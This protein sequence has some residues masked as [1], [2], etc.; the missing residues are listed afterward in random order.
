MAGDAL[1]GVAVL[2][3]REALGA[4]GD[5]LVELDVAPDDAGLADDH[6]R[7]VVDGEMAAYLR[8]GVYVD[9]RL[10]MGHFGDDAGNEGHAQHQ[11][12][13][14]DAVVA[15]GADAR[16]A[17]D[18]LAKRM[19]SGVAVVGGLHVGGQQ[20][21][22]AGQDADEVGSFPCGILAQGIGAAGS[23]AVVV[24]QAEGGQYLSAQL[25]EQ[26]FDVDADVVGQ[27][28]A[29][30]RGI[31]E[32]ARKDNGTRQF[33]NAPQVAARRQGIPLRMAQ[34][35]A[36]VTFGGGQPVDGLRQDVGEVQWTHQNVVA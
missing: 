26:L 17:A 31:S 14:G 3:Q 33:D 18:D 6:A 16:I 20:G 24:R 29:V 12:F 23:V 4:E 15:D 19:G 2:V 22:Q 8:A 36:L 21:A 5:A 13:V 32:V 30:H 1:D 11:Q 10:A 25:L 27:G 34:E 35:E 28:A 7:A 9:A